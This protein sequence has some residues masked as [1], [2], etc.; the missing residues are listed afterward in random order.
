MMRVASARA[1][2]AGLR[3]VEAHDARRLVALE[4]RRRR[5]GWTLWQS[6]AWRALLQAARRAAKL[7][8]LD[9][10]PRGFAPTPPCT[11]PTAAA[12]SERCAS[13]RARFLFY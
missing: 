5:P 8:Q 3:R 4:R 1:R 10:Q 11:C 7:Q 2:V 12:R 9:D 6:L 13:C